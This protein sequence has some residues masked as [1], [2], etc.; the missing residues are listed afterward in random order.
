MDEGMLNELLG[1][2][3]TDLGATIGAGGI[4]VGHRLGLYRALAEGPA[5]PEQL[6]RRTGTDTRYVTEWCYGQAA[7]GYVERDAD[8]ST[9]SLSEEQ[10]F[11]LTDPSGPLYLPGAFV[12]ALGTLRAEPQI[13]EAYRTGAGMGWHEHHE[14]VFTGCEMFFR[15]GYLANLVATW[16]PALD[17]VGE[18]LA[19]GG[20]VA[21]I[22]C[23]LGASTVL[24]A[25]A[26][27]RTTVTGSDYH[28]GSIEIARKRAAD[29][30][31]SANTRFEVA[32]A[33]GFSGSGYD[34]VATFDC[35]HDMGDPSS[36]AQH[37]RRAIADDGTWL[38]VEPIAA[39][40]AADNM[41][42]VG[43]VYYGFSGYLCVPNAK[44]QSGGY[45]LGAQAGEAA[46]RDIVTA[47]GFTRFE[48]ASETPFNAVF[49]ARP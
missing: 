39:D 26:Y 42:P 18:K 17:G 48:R 38:I 19:A 1:R 9:F 30:G 20:R 36:T 43:R 3:V 8:A 40:T 33:D 49:A 4:V 12:L 22:G 25:E 2:F 34:L 11:A 41:N 29:A 24:M 6:A 15:P 27:P 28:E 14:D 16:I 21:D 46:I 44:S 7:G 47:A 35:L 32:P 13:T 5:T 10:A 31:V 37:V 23:G 45:A